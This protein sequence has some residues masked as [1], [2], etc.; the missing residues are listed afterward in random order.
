MNERDIDPNSRKANSREALLEAAQ[1]LFSEKG[2]EAVSTRELA[3]AAGVN[4]G[5]IQY[6][7]GS[8]AKLFVETVQ[9]M[10]R[11]NGC[12]K[13]HF[14][15][16]QA[17]VSVDDAALSICRFVYE[18]LQYLLRPQG[19]QACRLMIREIFTEPSRDKEMYEALIS[20]VVNE[21][22]RPLEEMLTRAIRVLKP[23][24]TTLKL[25]QHAQSILGQC[26]VYVTHRPFVERLLGKDL[27]ESPVLEQTAEHICRFSL[28]ALQCPEPLVD[29][30]IPKAVESI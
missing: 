25:Q 24:C 20:S 2:Y 27:S 8:K 26:T 13:S 4:L 9:R 21:F 3:E 18:F 6:H 10:M 12:A 23:D 1:R 5:A 17:L 15:H 19:P 14:N 22:S 30:V 11:G 29:R 28:Q 7:F 16:D